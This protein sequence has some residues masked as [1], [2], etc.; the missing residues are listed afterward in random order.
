MPNTNLQ[1][2]TLETSLKYFEELKSK[3]DKWGKIWDELAKYV[4]PQTKSNKEIFDSTSIWSREQLASGLQSLLV[5]PAMNWFNLTHQSNSN[6]NEEFADD[7][8]ELEESRLW[9]QQVE[10]TILQIFNNP[11]SSFYN[12]I[13]EFFLTLT[14][15]G[16][17]IFYLEEEPSLPSGVLFRNINIRQCYFAED[18]TGKVSSMYRLF[19]MSVR[20]AAGK[21]PEFKPLQEKLEK[22]AD[23]EVEILHIVEPSNDKKQNNLKQASLK[24]TN[25]KQANLSQYIYLDTKEI[26]AESSYSY[27]PFMVCRWI[28][29][30][31]LL[32]RVA[33][34]L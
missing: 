33:S 29:D 24:Q 8:S 10:Q 4:C 25:Q 26:I 34:T 20:S 21:W 3:R 6:N 2:K 22:S 27:F 28:C 23:E 19:T 1:A 7:E 5:N 9:G 32:G 13:H 11:A 16:T 18:R 31:M 17:A 30:T 14:A 12:Q 15:Y